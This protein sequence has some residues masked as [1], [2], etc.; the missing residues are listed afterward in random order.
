MASVNFALRYVRRANYDKSHRL[1]K[2]DIET[3]A[4][5]WNFKWYLHSQVEVLF[6]DGLVALGLECVRHDIS[7]GTEDY[8]L[9]V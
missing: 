5:N 8:Q 6:S 7:V 2:E 4:I 3:M 9:R 1:C